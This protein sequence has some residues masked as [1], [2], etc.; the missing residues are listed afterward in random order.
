MR[1]EIDWHAQCLIPELLYFQNG[2]TF[3][4]SVSSPDEKDFRYRL[5]P[6]KE[7]GDGVGKAEPQK[8]I[9]AEVWYGPFCY[10]KSA[11]A[12]Q[13]SFPMEEQ[14]RSD[15]VDWLSQKYVSMIP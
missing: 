15:A 7:S 14:G 4:G 2:N 5:S 3:T 13:A 10:E 11:I 12:D 6:D 1:K 8:I 9:K